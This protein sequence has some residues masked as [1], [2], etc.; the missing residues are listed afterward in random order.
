MMRASREALRIKRKFCDESSE[1][2]AQILVLLGNSQRCFD[3]LSSGL[4]TFE[5]A[6]EIRKKLY[7]EKPSSNGYRNVVDCYCIIGLVH[8]VLGNKTEYVKCFKTALEVTTDCDLERSLEHSLIFVE[9][10]NW[11]VDE[12]LYMELLESNLPVI[13]GNFKWLLPILYLT[14]GSKQVEL[15]KH[16]AGLA[17]LQEA[18]DIDLEI[19]L[20]SAVGNRELTIAWYIKMVVTLVNIEKFNSARKAIERAIQVSESLPECKQYLWIFRCFM[21][22]GRFRNKMRE[23]ITAIESLK[24]ALLQLP[25]I[26]QK[27]CD[28]IEVFECHIAI[29]TAHIYVGSYKDAL[30][31]FYDALNVIK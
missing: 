9:L 23:Y 22:K 31:S 1:K 15:G 27:S 4:A 6:L 12:I 10:I 7:A 29:A 30:T 18:L 5:Q 11:K 25:K 14:L 21:W 17:F 24:H 13:K 28:K 8:N 16:K 20:R 2:I 26:S 19:T 3:D